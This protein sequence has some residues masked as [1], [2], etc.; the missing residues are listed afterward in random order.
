MKVL[1]VGPL[2]SPIVRRVRDG[3]MSKGVDVYVA[4]HNVDDDER[5]INLGELKSF[6]NYFYFYKIK[7]IIDKIKPDVIHAH[8]ANHYGLMCLFS[9]VPVVLALWG[10]EIMIDPYKGG[11][12]R[13][14]IFRMINFLVLRRANICHTSSQHI[15]DKAN[16]QYPR[17]KEKGKVFYWGLPLNS[18]SNIEYHAVKNNLLVEFKIDEEKLIVFPRGLGWVYNPSFMAEIINKLTEYKS[19]PYKIVVF[20]GFADIE[21]IS[22]FKSML[23]NPEKVLIIERLLNDAELYVLYSKAKFHV[24]VPISDALGGGVIEPA[25][26]GSIPILSDLPSYNEFAY[27]HGA[28]IIKDCT[29]NSIAKLYDFLHDG[30]ERINFSY[31]DYTDDAVL[32]KIINCYRMALKKNET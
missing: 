3:L 27:E 12:I 2:S 17:T 7:K 10:S 11:Y 28:Y 26:L 9:R 32:E 19:L 18:L 25:I 22:K 15:L 31:V 8:I 24:S 16:K 6:F 4:S 20:C 1:I 23:L 21:E 14:M 5:I 29:D 13:K 30:N